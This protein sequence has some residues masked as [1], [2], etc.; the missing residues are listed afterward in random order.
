MARFLLMSA[1]VPGH[2][3]PLQ[4]IVRELLGRGHELAWITGRAYQAHVEELGAR[5]AP[6][7]RRIDTSIK[8]TYDLFPKLRELQGLAQTRYYLRRVFLGPCLEETAVINDLLADY[9][10]DCFLGDNAV[11]APFFK[12][13]KLGR[14]RAMIAVLPCGLPSRD[15]APFGL[16]F[17]P[18]SSMF[19]RLRNRLLTT[20]VY[21][22]LLRD[23]NRA[24]NE[25]RCTLGLAPLQGP[26]LVDA[27]HTLDLILQFGTPAFEYPRSDLPDHVRFI[28]PVQPPP[29]A[30]YQ[31]PNWWP[32][33][34]RYAHVVL[35]NQ[36][37]VSMDTADLLL[38]ALEGLREE[39][40]LVIAV[41]LG[42]EQAAVLPPN[43][44]GAPFIPFAELLPHVDVMVTN[45]GY[46]GTQLALAHGIPLVVAGNTDD[47]MEV[48]ARV[49]WSGAGINLRK[50]RPSATAV[51]AA[52]REVL[53]DPAYRA[54]AQHIA[55]DFARYDASLRA[56]DLLEELLNAYKT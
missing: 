18:S 33:L 3:L 45:G 29:V 12:A 37:T 24:A 38:P 6:I 35:V 22:F 52:V 31:P 7:P 21:S 11:F 39:E 47:K 17:S 13:E 36:G 9:P 48:A 30:D 41:P 32:D 1:P 42:P 28:G 15:V 27:W 50:K 14:P 54:S 4:P 5:F 26:F 25:V 43:A 34:D 20:L 56:A 46:G 8:E 49:S 19:G 53:V 23:F 2:Y 10:A 40:L 51:R 55:Q 44:R 16:G